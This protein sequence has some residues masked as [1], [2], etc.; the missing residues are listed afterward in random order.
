MHGCCIISVA[1]DSKLQSVG[2][3]HYRVT[4]VITCATPARPELGWLYTCEILMLVGAGDTNLHCDSKA[5]RGISDF[6]FIGTK[7]CELV[8][9]Q[10]FGTACKHLKLDNRQRLPRKSTRTLENDLLTAEV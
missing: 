8:S 4:S 6:Y 2:C 1:V 3:L 5:H 7:V 9:A 10:F